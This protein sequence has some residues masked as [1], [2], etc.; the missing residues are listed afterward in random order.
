MPSFGNV[1]QC[2]S[3]IPSLLQMFKGRWDVFYI[4]LYQKNFS[5]HVPHWVCSKCVTHGSF[6]INAI[7]SSF[8]DLLNLVL[9]LLVLVC[10]SLDRS[11][12]DLCW[13]NCYICYHLAPRSYV[14]ELLPWSKLFVL[15]AQFLQILKTLMFFSVII[16]QRE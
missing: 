7:P 11:L 12:P 4:F 8:E 10:S 6:W 9:L 2:H 13:F 15:N 16:R 14:T 1:R 3:N 5:P